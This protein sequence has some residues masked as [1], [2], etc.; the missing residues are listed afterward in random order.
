MLTGTRRDDY[1]SFTTQGYPEVTIPARS[2]YWQQYRLGEKWVPVL[3]WF[4]IYRKIG[5]HCTSTL[6]CT[7]DLAVPP[8]FPRRAASDFLT[9]TRPLLSATARRW[10]GGVKSDSWAFFSC[11]TSRGRCRAQCVLL[12]YNIKH[13]CRRVHCKKMFWCRPLGGSFCQKTC[14]Y[15]SIRV[16]KLLVVLLG[17]RRWFF[18]KDLVDF[19]FLRA[20]FPSPLSISPIVLQGRQGLARSSFFIFMAALVALWCFSWILPSPSRS[21]KVT[22]SLWRLHPRWPHPSQA[23]YLHDGVVTLLLCRVGA[24]RT[25]HTT[26]S[27]LHM[28]W[29]F[30]FLFKSCWCLVIVASFRILF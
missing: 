8:S 23:K 26:T 19:C 13:I 5:S 17:V 18:V 21:G 11:A 10:V 22:C 16:E 25:Y 9:C 29:H 1:F 28:I 2:I 20:C 4:V 3:N 27:L 24:T 14:W 7:F 30:F 12:E 6:Y 15:S